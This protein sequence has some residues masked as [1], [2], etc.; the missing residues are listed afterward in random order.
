MVTV[1][2]GLPLWGFLTFDPNK[3]KTINDAMNKWV[4]TRLLLLPL[5]QMNNS[6]DKFVLRNHKIFGAFFV[7][8]ATFILFKFLG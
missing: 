4:S 5:E 7:I 1:I 6:F 2:L 8:A 3:V